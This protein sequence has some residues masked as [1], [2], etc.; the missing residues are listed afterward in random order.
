VVITKSL[1][2]E[3]R[4]ASNTVIYGD[5]SNRVF[6]ISGSGVNVTIRNLK[7]Q[8]G[9]ASSAN[10]GGI[11]GTGISALTLD[12]VTLTGNSA[13]DGGG[14]YLLNGDLTLQSCTLTGNAASHYGGAVYHSGSSKTVT[15]TS[16]TI[17]SSTSSNTALRVAG[18]YV[19][20]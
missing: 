20:D 8:N 15:M 16:N 10:G 1:T 19:L 9:N 7:I 5:G 11:Y 12:T 4:G 6:S 3:G 18:L 13:Y 14:V 2:I 17:G